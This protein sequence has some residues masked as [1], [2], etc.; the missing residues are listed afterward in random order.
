MRTIAVI[1]S[2]TL[3]LA[4]SGDQ[5]E[6]RSP[7]EVAS[8]GRACRAPR[9]TGR[10][11]HTPHVAGDLTRTSPSSSRRAL[12]IVVDG[13]NLG[14]GATHHPRRDVPRRRE[15]P[16]ARRARAG[17]EPRERRT[18]R[19]SPRR[20]QD[21]A[22]R[23]T[24]ACRTIPRQC[25]SSCPDRAARVPDAAMGFS[26]PAGTVVW[27]HGLGDHYE[28]VY[29]RR[30]VEDVPEGDW[31]APPVT[32]KLPDDTGYARDLRSRSAELRGD[33]AP[34]GRPARLSRAPRAQPPAELSVQAAL[35]R[36]QHQA[37]LGRGRPWRAR[38]RRRGAS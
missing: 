2:A 4:L 30:R 8:P 20:E 29:E 18:A 11:R 28:A 16:L 37:P 35:R 33:G 22:T 9:V 21:D 26:V 25:G 15:L 34:V 12:G 17:G 6:S 1:A 23:S 5:R 27:S 10:W 38:S 14:E 13:Q 36:R 7:V 24:C 19:R 32:F 31:A 3:W